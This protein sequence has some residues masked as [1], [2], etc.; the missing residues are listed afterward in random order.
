MGR[1]KF[2]L[3]LLLV[4][5]Y[6]TSKEN[7]VFAQG[8]DNQLWINYAVTIPI[9]KKWSYGGDVGLRGFISNYDW[10][11]ILIRP[12]VT[13]RINSI[14]SV[15]AAIALFST[16]NKNM[17]NVNEFRI[18]Q[19]VNARWPETAFGDFFFRVRIEQRF[20]FFEDNQIDNRFNVRLRGLAGYESPDFRPF[21]SKR[22]IYFQVMYEGFVTP[23]GNA[24]EVFVNQTRFDLAFGHRI[25]DYFRYE[26]HYIRQSSRLF[27]EDGLDLAQNI[28][29]IR[30]FHRIK[31]K[32]EK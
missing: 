28:L 17:G 8:A 26:L 15:S 11:Q 5:L 24:S 10:N 32:S 9:N 29:R 27:A 6:A 20:F 3:F 30:F 18:H 23:E 1:S 2:Y 7:V 19:D 14:F 13:Y 4:I 12:T 25:S 16:F 22:P 21:Q 31:G